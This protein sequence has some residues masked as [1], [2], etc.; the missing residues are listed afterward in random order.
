MSCPK[1]GPFQNNK[2]ADQNF[3]D[4]KHLFD[5]DSDSDSEFFGFDCSS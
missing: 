3:N 4:L 1:L 2:K 5:T